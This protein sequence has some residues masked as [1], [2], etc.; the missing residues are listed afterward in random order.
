MGFHFQARSVGNEVG[1]N[2][3]SRL[4]YLL[5]MPRSGTSWLAKIFDSHPE[6]LYRHEPDIAHRNDAIPYSCTREEAPVYIDA[7]QARLNLFVN[8]RS[9][10]TV[11]L[12]PVFAKS[13]HTRRQTV[14]RRLIIGASKGA[15]RIPFARRWSKSVQVPDFVDP[16]SDTVKRIIIKSVGA[17]MGRI[18]IIKAAAPEMQF[19]LLIRHPC[20]QVASM[21][22]GVRSSKFED[23]I[24][25]PEPDSALARQCGI[26]KEAL[27][28]MSLVAQLAW[29]WVIRNELVL[30]ALRGAARV[31]IVRYEEL[32]ADP[33]AVSRRIF[34]DCRLDWRE[35]TAKFIDWSTRATGT[36][37]YYQ[38]RRD[39]LQA[40]YDWRAQLT[41][42]EIAEIYGIVR[43]SALLAPYC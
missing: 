12:R 32:A 33:V 3:E 26:T 41:G 37:G 31:S 27:A 6:T 1:F 34:A 13:F 4:V 10:R 21:L 35:E 40:A 20:G 14:L 16:G 7:M 18:E 11:G 19:V 25:I 22:R 39:P 9:P 36:E 23:P 2:Y 29:S 42:A 8:D 24:H 28:S 15:E 17:P 5:G 38:V 30:E 43:R